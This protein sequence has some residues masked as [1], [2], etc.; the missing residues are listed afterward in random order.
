MTAAASPRVFQ[1]LGP[2]PR[3][4]HDALEQLGVLPRLQQAADGLPDARSRLNYIAAKTG[5]AAEKVLALVDR[6]KAERHAISS[7]ARRV[8]DA[9]RS[10]PMRALASGALLAFVQDVEASTSRIDRHLTDIVQAQDFHD[11]TGQVVAKVVALASELEESLVQLLVQAA[12]QRQAE[13]A[14]LQGPVVDPQG[15]TDVVAN[16][17]EVDDLLANLGF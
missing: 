8:A 4:L 12:P 15:R 11:L 13:P 10:D 14:S 6:A 3:Q 7:T 16:Q 9:L 17:A 1:P 2:M 5:D